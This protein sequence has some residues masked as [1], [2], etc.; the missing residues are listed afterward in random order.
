MSTTS[1]SFL[2]WSLFLWYSIWY[3]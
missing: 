1:N 2:W 3:N